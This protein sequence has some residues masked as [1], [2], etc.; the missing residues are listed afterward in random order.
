MRNCKV[1]VLP[2]VGPKT[3]GGTDRAARGRARVRANGARQREGRRERAG[4]GRAFGGLFSVRPSVRPH[5]RRLR[6]K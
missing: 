3:E 4:N 6:G 2:A 5:E 1:E